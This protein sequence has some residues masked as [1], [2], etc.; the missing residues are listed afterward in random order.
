MRRALVGPCRSR[1]TLERSRKLH[2]LPL[3]T[4]GLLL[5]FTSTRARSNVLS[6]TAEITQRCD[7]PQNHRAATGVVEV[8]GEMSQGQI[9]QEVLSQSKGLTRA[10]PGCRDQQRI[11]S[12]ANH[13]EGKQHLVHH[14]LKQHAQ[15]AAPPPLHLWFPPRIILSQ[16]A[17]EDFDVKLI[18]PHRRSDPGP[19][20]HQGQVE[21]S[22][23]RLAKH[24]GFS[25]GFHISS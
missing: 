22:L 13:Q 6:Q 19:V 16:L 8:S 20:K 24:E 5:R 2:L 3:K 14:P 21:A 10:Q 4:E 23:P 1:I 17:L 15:G 25:G 11:L 7:S 9:S 18:K 12:H